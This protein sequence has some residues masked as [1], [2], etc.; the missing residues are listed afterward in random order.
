MARK[1]K[2]LQA[3][4]SHKG[5]NIRLEKQRGQEKAA[6][7]R[8]LQQQREQADDVDGDGFEDIEDDEDDD[9]EDLE[10]G[11]GTLLTSQKSALRGSGKSLQ[12]C[13]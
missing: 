5:R 9:E 3:L 2:L 10:T 11:G 8:R 12:V 1:G 4:D 6:A 7:K 13:G